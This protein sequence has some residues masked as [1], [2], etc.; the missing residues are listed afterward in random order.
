[1]GKIRAAQALSTEILDCPAHL[2]TIGWK[3][4]IDLGESVGFFQQPP[5][6]SMTNRFSTLRRYAHVSILRN[7]PISMCSTIASN[8]ERASLERFGCFL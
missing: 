5:K 7:A 4:S 3:E 1:M 2:G 8:F 6:D